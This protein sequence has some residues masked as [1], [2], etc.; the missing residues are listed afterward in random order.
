LNQPAI[1]FVTL[2]VIA[3]LVAFWFWMFSDMLA[4]D[5]P[6][7]LPKT[8]WLLAFLVMNVFAAAMYYISE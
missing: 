4:N 2:L 5:Q 6:A 8:T 1:A 3:P 7:T